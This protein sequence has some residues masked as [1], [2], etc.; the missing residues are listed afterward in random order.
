MQSP[1]SGQESQSAKEN[2]GK[3]DWFG[4]LK[5]KDVKRGKECQEIH[6]PAIIFVAQR[7]KLPLGSSHPEA[8]LVT[9][10]LDEKFELCT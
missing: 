10:H 6:L 2:L 4:K 9:V 3:I 7:L 8:R 1:G 5:I